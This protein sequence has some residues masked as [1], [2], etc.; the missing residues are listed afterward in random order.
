MIERERFIIG[1]GRYP[2]LLPAMGRAFEV[3]D[4]L[5]VAVPHRLDGGT[6][7]RAPSL[8]LVTGPVST[9]C[10]CLASRHPPTRCAGFPL[11]AL[12]LTFT[13]TCVAARQPG[14]GRADS[15]QPLSTSRI[16][17][18]GEQQLRP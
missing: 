12:P 2:P 18:Y 6:S 3:R 8:F 15:R 17:T 14:V 10:F 7:N 9:P 1:A 16:L 13:F 11:K 5:N 4:L